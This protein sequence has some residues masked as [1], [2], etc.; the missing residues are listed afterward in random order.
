MATTEAASP[1]VPV[2]ILSVIRFPIGGIRSYLRYTYARLPPQD[3]STTVV[4]VDVKE[5]GLLV[6][7]MAPLEVDLRLVPERRAAVGLAR[8]MTRALRTR[9]YGLV[10]SQGST[11]AIA[12]WLG[13]WWY[14]VPHVVTL[15]ETFRDE[16]FAGSSGAVR[17][18]LLQQVFRRVDAIVVVSNDARDNLLKHVTLSSTTLKRLHVIHNGVAVDVLL[19]EA[20]TTRPELRTRLKI[21]ADTVLLGYV[22]RFMPEK[23]FDVLLDAVRILRD[24]QHPT[25]SFLVVAVNDGAF[26]REYRRQIAALD[27]DA[28]FV[29]EGLR[30]S[31]AGTLVELDAA[32]MPSRREAFG[33]VAIEALVLGCP[34]LASDCIGLREQTAGTPALTSIAGDARA[35]ADSIETFL[36]NRQDVTEQTRRYVP[37]A[38]ARFDSAGGVDR[39]VEVFAGAFAARRS[40]ATH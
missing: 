33:L 23:G 26:V 17:R 22:G 40:R 13:A 38:R 16:Q 35:L 6:S 9:R 12:S 2:R 32:I 11:A 3:Y 27:L 10:H 25:G 15:H 19:R 36:R 24:R 1:H 39:L 30:S 34:L 20:E 7:G 4:T 31:A 14:G 21:R 28:Y 29:F 8:E 37:V 5:A 18:Q